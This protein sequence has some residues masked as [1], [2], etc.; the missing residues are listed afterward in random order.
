MPRHD[1]ESGQ[2]EVEMGWQDDVALVAAKLTEMWGAET[3]IEQAQAMLDERQMSAAEWLEWNA[4]L[5]A[6]AAAYVPRPP[7]DPVT[8]PELYEKYLQATT[9]ITPEVWE[10]V[11][12]TDD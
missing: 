6:E 4:A 3:S 10:R 9:L 2:G 11:Q 7:P 8:E 1:A 12:W 5:A